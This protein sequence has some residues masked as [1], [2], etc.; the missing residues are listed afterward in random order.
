[1]RLYLASNDLGSFANTL[2]D[3]VG[4][5]KKALIISNARDHRSPDDRKAIVDEDTKMLGDCG[6]IVSELDLRE[7]FGNSQQ[8][9]EYVDSFNPGLVFSMGGNV[10]SLA[11]ALKLSGMDSVLREDLE[12][13]KYVYGGYSA[14]SMV[15]S[16]DLSN[17]LDSYGRRSD[18]R[19]EQARELYGEVSTN[20][21]G[22]IDEYIAPHADE[23]RFKASCEE[24][25]V[26]ISSKGLTPI[27]LNNSDVVVV[28]GKKIIKF[29][30]KDKNGQQED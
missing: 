13:D 17:Y 23:E 16:R 30:G 12:Q 21:L 15:A 7:Y 4:E 18:D 9:K 22:L 24:A 20:G 1:M 19:L 25:Q 10:Y 5:N 8:L 27:A 2:V 26:S 11:T 6:F 3:L 29:V 14:G 28:N